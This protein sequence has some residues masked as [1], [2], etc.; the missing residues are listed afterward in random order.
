MIY[1][2]KMA[3]QLHLPLAWVNEHSSTWEAS[4]KYNLHND[5]TGKLDSAAAGLL[6]DQ[7]LKEGPELEFKTTK[8]ENL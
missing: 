6:L 7:W 4:K 8:P 2:I 1:G 3:K 5:R